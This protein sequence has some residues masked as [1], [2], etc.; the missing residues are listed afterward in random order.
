MTG[1]GT[2][3]EKEITFNQWTT[4]LPPE[5]LRP[6]LQRGTVYVSTSL[7][8][9]TSSFKSWTDGIHSTLYDY[10]NKLYKGHEKM[11]CLYLLPEEHADVA[12]SMTIPFVCALPNL[13]LLGLTVSAI[14]KPIC[15]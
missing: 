7:M 13:Q 3:R 5:L 10:T 6:V 9:F 11:H 14:F 15:R 8:F 1:C 12:M 2:T 4:H